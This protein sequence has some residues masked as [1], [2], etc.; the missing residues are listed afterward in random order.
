MI[1]ISKQHNGFVKTMI[2]FDV[3][4]N[5]MIFQSTAEFVVRCQA[6]QGEYRSVPR[7]SSRVFGQSGFTIYS[8]LEY[9]FSLNLLHFRYDFQ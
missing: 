9:T 2:E 7:P 1:L 6:Y 8:V 5:L 3:A 4:N